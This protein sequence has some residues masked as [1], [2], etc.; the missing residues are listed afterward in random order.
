MAN[1][2]LQNNVSTTYTTALKEIKKNHPGL[3]NYATNGITRAFR[4]VVKKVELFLRYIASPMRDRSNFQNKTLAERI[5]SIKVDSIKN[6]NTNDCAILGDNKKFKMHRSSIKKM[7]EAYPKATATLSK[8]YTADVEK[9]TEKQQQSCIVFDANDNTVGTKGLYGNIK[10]V[11]EVHDIID[12]LF[13]NFIHGTDLKINSKMQLIIE[14]PDFGCEGLD[15]S[16]LDGGNLDNDNLDKNILVKEYNLACQSWMVA[17]KDKYNIE[18]TLLPFINEK[19]PHMHNPDN[20]RVYDEFNLKYVAIDKSKRARKLEEYVNSRV[21]PALVSQVSDSNQEKD[22]ESVSPMLLRYRQ[23]MLNPDVYL[24]NHDSY[25]TSENFNGAT[26]SNI[27][28]ETF[29]KVTDISN[30]TESEGLV[31]AKIENNDVIETITDLIEITMDNIDRDEFIK[32]MN[33]DLNFNPDINGITESN[34]NTTVENTELNV[35]L[36]TNVVFADAIATAQ[37]SSTVQNVNLVKLRQILH[38][39]NFLNN[40]DGKVTQQRTN[41]SVSISYNLDF[42]LTDRLT[43]DEDGAYQAFVVLLYAKTQAQ[44]LEHRKIT[45]DYNTLINKAEECQNNLNA[46]PAFI[47]AQTDLDTNIEPTIKST[48]ESSIT[49][50]QTLE[51]HT[52]TIDYN[53]LINQDEEYQNSLNAEQPLII[54]AQTLGPKTEY[55]TKREQT[56]KVISE[57]SIKDSIL[58][59]IL[60]NDDY[61]ENHKISPEDNARS[62]NLENFRS[63]FFQGVNYPGPKPVMKAPELTL[64]KKVAESKPEKKTTKEVATNTEETQDNNTIDKKN[65]EKLT[66]NSNVNINVYFPKEFKDILENTT[67][68]TLADMVKRHGAEKVLLA[69]MN[70][71]V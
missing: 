58:G 32:C 41:Q 55:D 29:I 26:A 27:N 47:G 51:H 64:V 70:V 18:L 6:I 8:G 4:F 44:I 68:K 2:L 69:A 62:S 7:L 49:Q 1:N 12:D 3:L 30:N 50:A 16:N 57:A 40:T 48:G 5:L 52:I 33:D 67:Y 15:S 36:T 65:N 61:I 31:V 11:V 23:A 22:S 42:N 60:Y 71:R 45:V 21:M 25:D 19:V 63:S 28:N 14:L 34:N 39:I 10:N 53:T 17:L 66:V 38:N 56:N 43:N 35:H 24:E 54:G 20:N 13:I 46:E 59:E 9:L 37:D